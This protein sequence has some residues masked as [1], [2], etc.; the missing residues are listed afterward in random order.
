MDVHNTLMEYNAEL[1]LLEALP[2]QDLTLDDYV[3]VDTDI[4]EWGTLSDAE[5]VALDHNNTES[6]DKSELTPITLT[7][8]KV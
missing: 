5:I 3:Q 6:D 1:S 8:A 7:E 4:T 2:V